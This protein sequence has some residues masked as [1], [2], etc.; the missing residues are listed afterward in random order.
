LEP[1]NLEKISK[2]ILQR[3]YCQQILIRL[4]KH[5]EFAESTF[6]KECNKKTT[7]A[8]S[9]YVILAVL[10]DKEKVW[11]SHFQFNKEEFNWYHMNWLLHDTYIH[12]YQRSIIEVLSQFDK[13]IKEYKLVYSYQWMM[14]VKLV[15][16]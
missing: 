2:N 14:N 7:Q 13:H 11:Q 12:I 9:D 4:S 1:K 5:D 8:A 10:R 3:V 6:E 16:S 15:Q